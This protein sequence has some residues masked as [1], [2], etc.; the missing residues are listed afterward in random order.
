VNWEAYPEDLAPLHAHPTQDEALGEASWLAENRSTRG[1]RARARR[2]RTKLKK[3][4][5]SK[6]HH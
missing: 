1:R 2:H 6:E 4:N 3:Q 5:W